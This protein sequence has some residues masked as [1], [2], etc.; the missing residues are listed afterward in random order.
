MIKDFNEIHL[1][2]FFEQTGEIDF[3][4]EKFKDFIKTSVKIKNNNV[5]SEDKS[6]LIDVPNKLLNYC[7]DNQNKIIPFDKIKEFCK[8]S[9]HYRNIKNVN[10][11]NLYF[12]IFDF[13][14]KRHIKKFIFKAF[15]ID[16][17]NIDAFNEA[18]K[19]FEEY[20]S[21]L[22]G[23]YNIYDDTAICVINENSSNLI[24]TIYHELSHYIQQTC[25]IRITKNFKF[26]ENKL[27][28]N[29]RFKKL[30][31]LGITFNDL[32]Y[33]FSDKEFDV[34]VDELIIGLWKTYIKYYKDEY[35][36]YVNCFYFLS[37]IINE[38]MNNND[39]IHS[40]FAMNYMLANKNNLAPLIMF[41]ASFYFNHK[42]QKIKSLVS[43]ALTKKFNE[44]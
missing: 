44:I 14:N 38:I 39:F 4:I 8:Q 24:E 7:Y 37:M 11:K 40:K 9:K 27:E 3:D 15:K 32:N 35:D 13:S 33:Y 30:K 1:H 2:M 41:A 20:C 17:E 16:P 31:S 25:T 26:D 6:L 22:D 18:F 29:E 10:G 34:H 28:N 19:Y 36:Q 43:H 12:T 5:I 42:Y 21:N 23:F